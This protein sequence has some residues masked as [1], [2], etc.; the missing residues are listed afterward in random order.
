M[1]ISGMGIP[2]SYE[3]LRLAFGEG[4]LFEITNRSEGGARITMGA[5]LNG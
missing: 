3:R 4:I 2:N 1:S 5:G